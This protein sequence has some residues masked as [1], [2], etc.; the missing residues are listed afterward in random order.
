MSKDIKQ[1]LQVYNVLL[2][3]FIFWFLYVYCYGDLY[4]I[5]FLGKYMD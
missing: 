4:D 5:L 1:R 3:I 2:Y